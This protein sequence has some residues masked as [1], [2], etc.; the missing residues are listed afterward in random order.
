[1][2]DKLK[3]EYE[4]DDEQARALLERIRNR[5]TDM[6][7]VL[8]ILGEIALESIETNF[9][10][11]GRPPWEPLSEDTIE[12]RKKENKWPGQILVR[13]GKA[14]GLLGSLNYRTV[15][16]GVVLSANKAYAALHQFGAHRGEFGTVPVTIPEHART[17]KKGKKYRVKSHQRMMAIPWADIPARPYMKIQD[18]D[19]DE[20]LEALKTYL[21]RI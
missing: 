8:D 1:M 13:A 18:E 17:S 10:R 5:I 19:M 16:N 14:G 9:E 11:G 4:L 21:E 2:G 7:P 15:E 12:D 3:I 20:M 6:T